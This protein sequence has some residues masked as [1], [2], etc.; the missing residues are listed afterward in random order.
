RWLCGIGA[1]ALE[2]R[3]AAWLHVLSPGDTAALIVGFGLIVQGAAVL[4]LRH[5][6]RWEWL[7]PFLLGGALG[8]PFGTACSDG[9]GPISGGSEF[10][11]TGVRADVDAARSRQWMTAGFVLWSI[12][13]SSRQ[14]SRDGG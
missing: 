5:V 7:W 12:G 2:K 1:L 13:T 14:N 9:R 11:R 6:L 4:K 3:A 10:G 8:V